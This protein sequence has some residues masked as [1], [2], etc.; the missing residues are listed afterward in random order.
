MTEAKDQ[1]QNRFPRDA[2]W[3]LVRSQSHRG[4]GRFDRIGRANVHPVLGR[5]VVEGTQLFAVFLKTLNRLRVLRAI[6]L[7]EGIERL[8]CMRACGRYPDLVPRRLRFGLN[9]FW[10][11]IEHIAR[12][13]HPAALLARGREDFL[14]RRPEAHRTVTGR[15]L[16]GIG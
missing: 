11:R 4:K 3:R 10:H 6:G 15:Q 7:D 16:R 13:V 8:V 14:E 5:E 9:A 1:R 2:P 12:F